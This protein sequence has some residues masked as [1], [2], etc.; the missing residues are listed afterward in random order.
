MDNELQIIR[1]G[2]VGGRIIRNWNGVWI[3]LPVGKSIIKT[4][5][6]FKNMSIRFK[7]NKLLI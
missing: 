1:Q 7:E 2:V 6:N 3:T 5:G 4:S